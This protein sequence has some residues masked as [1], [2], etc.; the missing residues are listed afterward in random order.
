V[1]D[2]LAVVIVS[3]ECAPY[4]E[5]CLRSVFAHAGG[6]DLDVVVVDAGSSD[7]GPEV[8]E[9]AFPDVRVLRGPNRG[10]AH[11]N[12]IGVLATDAPFVLFLNPDTEILEGTLAGLVALLADRP[13]VG[14]AGCRQVGP[15]GELAP[16]I[17]RFPSPTRAFMEA[18]G[19]ERLPVRASWLG[20]RELDPAPYARETACDWTSGSFMVARR[21]ALLAAGLMDERFFIY[22]EEPDLCRRIKAAG[23]DVAHLPVMTILHHA[24]KSGWSERLV[25]QD[26]FARRQY[27]TKHL[28]RPR[29]GLALSAHAL[30]LAIRAALGAP[31]RRR[32][33]RAGLRTLTGRVPPPFGPPPPTALRGTH[34]D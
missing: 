11:A 30:G 1:R 15:D 32:A 28:S 2:E 8:V 9:R 25:A 21:D 24:G 6:A 34:G 27:Y 7:G 13:R 33:C 26:A 31:D 29:A 23:W 10:F 14:L 12:N 3:H 20:E 22:C 5:P 4:L 16:S 18:L 17:R 19:S